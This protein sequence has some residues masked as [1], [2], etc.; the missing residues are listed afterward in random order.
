MLKDLNLNPAQSYSQ[1]IN[2]VGLVST[3]VRKQRTE[4]PTGRTRL[5]SDG[6]VEP[7]LSIL[8]HSGHIV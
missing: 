6:D 7:I 5:S 8:W 4:G 2:H 3:S 1:A